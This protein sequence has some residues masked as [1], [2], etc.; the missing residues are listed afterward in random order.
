MKKKTPAKKRAPARKAAAKK[1]V[2]K[3]LAAKKTAPKTVP[4]K[5]VKAATRKTVASRP[6]LRVP[7]IAQAHGGVHLPPVS[8]TPPAYSA[9]HQRDW[10]TQPP[11]RNIRMPK[12]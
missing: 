11:P 7:P 1:P 6:V 5:A 4:R 12:R 10:A 8:H 2:R 9:M 3:K